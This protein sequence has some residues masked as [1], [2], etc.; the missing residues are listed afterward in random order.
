MLMEYIL[1]PNRKY[2]FQF[3]CGRTERVN[4]ILSLIGQ[5]VS[6]TLD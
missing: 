1:S 5:T 3:S 4:A 6:F 2:I